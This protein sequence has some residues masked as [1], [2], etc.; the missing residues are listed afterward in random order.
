MYHRS[1]SVAAET[2]GDAA[3]PTTSHS[4]R[5]RC[6][7]EYLEGYEEGREACKEES[8]SKNLFL[9]PETARARRAEKE[10]AEK[11]AEARVEAAQQVEEARKEGFMEG[12][13]AG[14][15]RVR[16]HLEGLVKKAGELQDNE[17]VSFNSS[18]L[19]K[20]LAK[21][22]NKGVEASIQHYQEVGEMYKEKAMAGSWGCLA[23]RRRSGGCLG[24]RVV[25]AGATG[26][27]HP[28]HAYRV[29]GTCC[30]VDAWCT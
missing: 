17:E 14:L 28:R 15:E 29:A 22:Q 20:W 27:C 30:T 24:H 23:D 3:A 26:V 7:N 10:S 11:L 21:E 2:A 8:V 16:S 12:Q 19:L 6:A 4:H 5:T 18:P 1:A 9:G 25:V 13:A